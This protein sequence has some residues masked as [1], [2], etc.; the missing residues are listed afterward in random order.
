MI[1]KPLP[2]S[3]FGPW[4]PV[5]PVSPFSPCGPW[6]PV[7]P[8]T[9]CGPWGPCGPRRFTVPGFARAPSLVQERLPAASTL[10]VKV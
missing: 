5:S 8:L 7:S 3:P 1:L 4:G 6:G 2:V 9:P 10:G